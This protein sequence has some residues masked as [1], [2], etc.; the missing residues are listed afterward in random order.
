MS[1]FPHR[2]FDRNNW[3][4][5]DQWTC[6]LCEFKNHQSSYCALCG[7]ECGRKLQL[8]EGPTPSMSKHTVLNMNHHE[9]EIQES[10]HDPPPLVLDQLSL[11]Q[12][13]A[14]MRK[15]WTLDI[16]LDGKQIWTRNLRSK[17]QHGFPT[18]DGLVAKKVTVDDRSAHHRLTFTECSETTS[19]SLEPIRG[20][21]LTC[22]ELMLLEHMHRQ[23]D[24]HMK[25]AWFLAQMTDLMSSLDEGRLR[26]RIHRHNLVMDSIEQLVGISQEHLHLQMRIEFMGESGVDAGGLEREWVAVFAQQIFDTR[27]GLFHDQGRKGVYTINPHSA[28]ASVDHLVYF[29]GIGRFIGR[30]LLNGQLLPIRLALPLFKHMLG[31]PLTFGDLEFFDPQLFQN[32]EWIQNHEGVDDLA[33]DFSVVRQRNN[34]DIWDL[35]PHGRDIP[36]TDANKEE[37]ILL[38]FKYIMLGSIAD[39]LQSLLL[40]LFEV[41]GSMNRHM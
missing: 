11:R 4:L 18:L 5:E 28:S 25:Y 9:E 22:D 13:M 40:G 6:Y 37:Y 12:K 36:V 30:V 31:T 34:D 10:G 1:S 7:T 3:T 38:Y 23:E 2:C 41:R 27:V 29:R 35:K 20:Y 14:R 33:L 24:F 15:E 32:L 17:T 19:A 21:E 8:S 26:L 39:Q 16:N